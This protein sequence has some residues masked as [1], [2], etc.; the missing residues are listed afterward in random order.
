M[1]TAATWRA[2]SILEKVLEHRFIAEISTAL[3][4]KGISDF[5]VLRSEV[6]SRGYDLVVE[7]RGKQRHIQLKALRRGGKRRNVTLSKRLAEKPSG[8]VIWMVYDP[9]T[10]ATGPFLWLG[11]SPG[12][13]LAELGERVARHTR[14]NAKGEKAPRAGHRVVKKS[15]FK[16]VANVSDLVDALF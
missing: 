3:W 16:K 15:A 14:G 4:C 1:D 5:E 9:E 13:P 7:A 11:G 8:C 6:D 12:E 10:L 2:S